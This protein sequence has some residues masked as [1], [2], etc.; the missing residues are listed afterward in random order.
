MPPKKK[1]AVAKPKNQ[2][3]AIL[4]SAQNAIQ[5]RLQKTTQQS[6]S[7]PDVP[8]PVEPVEAADSDS[9]DDEDFNPDVQPV[10]AESSS[11]DDEA[12]AETVK[13]GAKK[14]KGKRKRDDDEVDAELASGDEGI[15]QQRTS[16]RHKKGAKDDFFSDDEGGEAGFIKTRAQ[17]R[18]EYGQY[19]VSSLDNNVNSVAGSKKDGRLD[20]SEMRL[21]MSMPYGQGSQLYPLDDL[22][23]PLNLKLL[24][25]KKT[26][27]RFNGPQSLQVRSRRKSDGFLELHKR[28]RSISR[29]RKRARRSSRKSKKQN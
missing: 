2:K 15:I 27:L 18:T 12:E 4:Q 26:T 5:E 16:K 1:K 28:P 29:N 22:Q 17:R 19:V 9:S 24:R 20:R 11:S 25:M 14:Q 21:L 13:P 10:E 6:P 3:E 23:S 8:A 7:K